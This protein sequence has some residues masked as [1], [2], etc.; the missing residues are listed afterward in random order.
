MT[1]NCSISWAHDLFSINVRKMTELSVG[2]HASKF[3][4]S[5]PSWCKAHLWIQAFA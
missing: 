4:F 1:C 2:F 3:C 5:Y